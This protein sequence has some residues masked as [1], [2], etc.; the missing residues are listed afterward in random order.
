MKTE[1][2]DLLLD[3][4]RRFYQDFGAAF[5][6]T[7]QRIQPGIRR[8]LS[9]LPMKGNW[10]DMGC[11]NGALAVEWGHSAL[12]GCYWGLDSSSALLAV[13]NKSV[14]GISDE[15]VQIKFS[16]CD[17]ADLDFPPVILGNKKFQPL[18]GIFCFA[19]LHHLPSMELRHAVLRRARQLLSVG[20]LFIHSVWQFKNSPRLLARVQPWEWIGISINDV[21]V[22]D[23]LLD[24]RFA[25]PGQAEV[26]GLRYVHHFS[27][28]ELANL[29]ADSGF[30]IADEFE[31]DGEGGRLG[32]YQV[33]ETRP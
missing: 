20:G 31:S 10:L 28:A 9:S 18:A 2:I 8:I 25:L 12:E 30:S 32:L 6:A 24:W 5:A 15:N 4:N 1:I 23:T 29:A 3:L 11:G 19:V 21:D 7:R 26:R 27:S 16:L 14:S 17:L 13:A 22:G 33:W